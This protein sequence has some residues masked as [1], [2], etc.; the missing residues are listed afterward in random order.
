MAKRYKSQEKVFSV[1]MAI[2]EQR[3]EAKSME[4]QSH[5][6]AERPVKQHSPWYSLES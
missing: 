2:V 1:L 5:P 3:L 4:S 6:Q